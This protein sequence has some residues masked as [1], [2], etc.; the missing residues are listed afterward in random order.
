[1]KIILLTLF[2]LPTFLCIDFSFPL[3]GKG[4]KCLGE[5]L[6][7]ET[8]AVVSVK[9]SRNTIKM[10]VHNPHGELIAT[11]ENQYTF[12]IGFSAHSSGNY[13]VC[14]ENKEEQD[15][16]IVFQFLSGVDAK[17][18]SEVAKKEN[19]KPIELNIMKLEDTVTQLLTE[20][21]AVMTKEQT[22]ISLND[23][24]SSKVMTLS[25][26]TLVIMVVIGLM[27]TFYIQ[28]YLKKKKLI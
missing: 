25:I 18:Y 28:K 1:M 16:V 6:T 22:T 23:S 2:L 14:F 15:E 19:L 24:I 11:R 3:K 10:K 4:S 20:L 27:Q 7:E 9:T 12:K 5:Y 21:N 26:G 13:Q 17:D 8:L